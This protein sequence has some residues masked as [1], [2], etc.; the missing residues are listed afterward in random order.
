MFVFGVIPLGFKEAEKALA[1]IQNGYPKAAADA[2]NRGLLAGR[3]AAAKS[4]SARYAIT[5]TNVKSGFEMKKATWSDLTGHLM[6]KGPMMKVSAF[7]INVKVV[8]GHTVVSTIIIKGQKKLIKGAFQLPDGRIMER[9]Q[10]SKFPIFPVMTIGIPPM[11]G[12]T[13]VSKEIQ[14]IINKATLD[15]LKHNTTYALERLHK[16]SARV[17][18]KAR[19]KLTA[20]EASLK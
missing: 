8:K 6:A 4:I 14:T 10:P 2:I 19:Q 5:S 11:A 3:T 13:G 18:A 17:R 15:R 16:D 1:G 20:K 7:H 12:E 9:R